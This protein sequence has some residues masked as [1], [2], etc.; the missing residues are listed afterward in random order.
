MRLDLKLIEPGW[1]G[2]RWQQARHPLTSRF[3][4]GVPVRP[5][6]SGFGCP[7]G[8]I[9]TTCASN[10]RTQSKTLPQALLALSRTSL[11]PGEP[12]SQRKPWCVGCLGCPRS[13]LALKPPLLD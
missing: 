3:H 5:A 9:T 12:G 6:P 1:P 8:P 4:P 11:L 13:P 10:Q 2:N 7:G